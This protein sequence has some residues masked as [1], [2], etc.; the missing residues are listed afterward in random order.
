MLKKKLDIKLIGLIL[1]IKL[2]GL[3][4]LR[5]CQNI[6]FYIH[7]EMTHQDDVI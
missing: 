2:I 1:D 3:N 5:H 4:G 7:W 6:T